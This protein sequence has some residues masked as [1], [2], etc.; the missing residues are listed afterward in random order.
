MGGWAEQPQSLSRLSR[1]RDRDEIVIKAPSPQ[2]RVETKVLPNR[3]FV[4]VV[5]KPSSSKPS[6][7]GKILDRYSAFQASQVSQNKAPFPGI[8]TR[9]TYSGPSI[10]HSLEPLWL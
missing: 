4:S 6:A 10:A 2:E 9:Q 1:E 8:E 3:S 7:L 5:K